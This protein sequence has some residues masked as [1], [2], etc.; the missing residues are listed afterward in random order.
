VGEEVDMTVLR[1]GRQV[2][3]RARIGEPFQ[4]T[5]MAGEA[6]PQLAG[7]RVADLAPGMPMYGQIEAVVVAS[8]DQASAA[9]KNG[10][11]PADLIY[12]VNRTRVRNVKQ[13][14]EALRTAEQPLRLAL[15]RGDQRITLVIR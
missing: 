10:L 5:A 12:G 15:L 2:R 13:L 4:V 14:F 3:V 11:R 7:A 8:V 6:V 9:F 1:D